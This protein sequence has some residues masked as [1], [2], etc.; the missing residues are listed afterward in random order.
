[1]LLYIADDDGGN[2]VYLRYAEGP[3]PYPA[4]TRKR[5]VET[6]MMRPGASAPGRR[7]VS[8]LGAAVSYADLEFEC[9]YISAATLASLQT[10]FNVWP[11]ESVRVGLTDDTGTTVYLCA[12]AEDGMTVSRWTADG[13]RFS[14]QFKFHVL[15]VI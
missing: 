3:Y 4:E 14:V 1:M 6:H 10:K 2:I 8:D 7:V 15:E 11:P 5:R 13:N 12:W 9:R